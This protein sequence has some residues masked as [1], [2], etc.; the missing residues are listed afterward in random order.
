MLNEEG[1]SIIAKASEHGQHGYGICSE[2]VLLALLESGVYLTD[3]SARAVRGALYHLVYRSKRVRSAYVDKVY[4]PDG[5]R[6]MEA[7]A[8]LRRSSLRRSVGPDELFVACF[9]PSVATHDVLVHYGVV[10]STS[11]RA[12]SRRR[13]LTVAVAIAI[14]LAGTPAAIRCFSD[15]SIGQSAGAYLAFACASVVSTIT[16]PI[17][18]RILAGLAYLPAHLLSMRIIEATSASPTTFLVVS[19]ALLLAIPLLLLIHL[20]HW[21]RERQRNRL[22]G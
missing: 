7:A 22:L 6:L 4:S 8:S 14:G 12:S 13:M 9:D 16:T 2:T 21:F 15:I 17:P 18:G 5:K 3:D 20:G 10:C 19:L 11:Y 1:R